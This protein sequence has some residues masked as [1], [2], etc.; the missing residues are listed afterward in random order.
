MMRP[1]NMSSSRLEQ[2]YKWLFLALPVLY[3][4][5]FGRHGLD[6]TDQGFITGLSHRILLG[7]VPYIDFLYV[8][9]PGSPLLHTLELWVLPDAWEFL[10]ARFMGIFYLW[11]AY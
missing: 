9:P 11:G 10:G 8:R 5:L 2:G 6:E 1:A 7:E 4:I 3:F